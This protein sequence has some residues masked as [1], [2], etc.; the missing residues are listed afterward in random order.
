MQPQPGSFGF[1]ARKKVTAMNNERD[2]AAPAGR[3][4]MAFRHMVHNLL[5]HRRD[6]SATSVSMS[7]DSPARILGV[8]RL[9]SAAT[10]LHIVAPTRNAPTLTDLRGLFAD[11]GHDEGELD[12]A[13]AGGNMRGKGAH[14]W[15]AVFTDVGFIAT[16]ANDT[17]FT[18][19]VLS[20]RTLYALR[21]AHNET[22]REVNHGDVELHY[23]VTFTREGPS[24]EGPSEGGDEAC[25]VTPESKGVKALRDRQFLLAYLKHVGLLSAHDGGFGHLTRL[26][27]ALD[28]APNGIVYF[29]PDVQ[30]L[31]ITPCGTDICAA[32]DVSDTLRKALPNMLLHTCGLATDL[33]PTPFVVQ[34]TPVDMASGYVARA[35]AAAP[36]GRRETHTLTLNGHE[37]CV[38]LFALPEWP[39]GMPPLGDDAP[40][41]A[42]G[43]ASALGGAVLFRHGAS[44]LN[45][46]ELFVGATQRCVSAAVGNARIFREVIRN[47]SL[48]YLSIIRAKPHLAPLLAFHDA[49]QQPCFY[50]SNGVHMFRAVF[51]AKNV[52][53]VV[54]AVGCAPNVPKTHL[55][56]PAERQALADEVAPLAWLLALKNLAPEMRAALDKARAD[57][58]AAA[59]K[60]AAA[61]AAAAKAAKAAKAKQDATAAAAAAQGGAGPAHVS[62]APSPSGA[63]PRPLRGKAAAAAAAA[64]AAGA[65]H[66]PPASGTKRPADDDDAE[67]AEE[68]GSGSEDGAGAGPSAAKPPRKQPKT[69][70]AAAAQLKAARAEVAALKQQLAALKQQLAA[71]DA[72][73][74]QLTAQLAQ[75]QH[76]IAA[77]A[78]AATAAAEADGMAAG[79]GVDAGGAA[80]GGVKMEEEE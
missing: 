17:D 57:A 75:A 8:P 35:V 33:P 70:A 34:G 38:D 14:H 36:G 37:V 6:Y 47:K 3:P 67:E 5:V 2:E 12:G 46:R 59:T 66:T 1:T 68:D 63:S 11:E 49:L 39:E 29:V 13:R 18:L 41:G 62:A 45:E 32:G 19:A 4:L 61:K 44:A 27:R 16:K 21:D 54:N 60:A 31:A 71:R 58:D 10:A 22:H 78:A 72:R 55:K 56:E 52:L 43:S 77:A 20:G 51:G 30:Q 74:A 42:G 65:A 15:N 26:F 28:G 64:A 23:F 79:G 9:S 7:I 25:F 40:G 76:A 50:R 53:A 80:G 73:N 48:P 24:E 69:G